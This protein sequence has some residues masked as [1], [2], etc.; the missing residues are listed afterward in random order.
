MSQHI[1]IDLPKQRDCAFCAYLRGDRPYTVWRRFELSSVLVTREQRGISH[2]LVIPNRHVPSL[3]DLHDDEAHE[4]IDVVRMSASA[5]DA[6]D[7]RPGISVWQN[8][9][10]GKSVV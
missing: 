10:K 7:K 6:V 3:L 9:G 5:I 2:V 1:G 4:I 8:N